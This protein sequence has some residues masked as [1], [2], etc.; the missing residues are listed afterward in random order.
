MIDLADVIIIIIIISGI[1]GLKAQHDISSEGE[2]SGGTNKEV[3][4]PRLAE[5]VGTKEYEED[6]DE[7]SE[8][9]NEEEVPLGERTLETGNTGFHDEVSHGDQEHFGDGDG[10]G[11][12]RPSQ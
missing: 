1:S 9:N 12:P 2:P 5:D 4:K 11:S 10:Q 3:K 7:V 8:T 6:K